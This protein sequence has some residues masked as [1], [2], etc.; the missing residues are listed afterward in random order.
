[1]RMGRCQVEV[2]APRAAAS[3]ESLYAWLLST[4]SKK[5]SSEQEWL[6]LQGRKVL[7]NSRILE[8]ASSENVR[9]PQLLRCA[10]SNFRIST[11]ESIELKRRDSC[12]S[13]LSYL[14]P[15]RRPVDDFHSLLIFSSR[16][17][18][19]SRMPRESIFLPRIHLESLHKLTISH[20]LACSQ[21]AKTYASGH[22][23]GGSCDSCPT[24]P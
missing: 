17:D 12:A 5:A 11:M 18:H 24:H 22:M 20:I 16:K 13:F 10:P 4:T 23:R 8:D 7:N 14:L 19:L 6:V 15:E 1:M 21:P 3:F 2:G 9:D